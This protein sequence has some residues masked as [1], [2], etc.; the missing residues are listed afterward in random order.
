MFGFGTDITA[1]WTNGMALYGGAWFHW[2]FTVLLTSQ[3][4]L[5]QRICTIRLVIWPWRW[6]TRNYFDLWTS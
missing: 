4:W 2:F 1:G 5:P 6:G 3:Q